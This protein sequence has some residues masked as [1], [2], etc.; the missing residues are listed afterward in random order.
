MTVGSGLLHA[1]ILCWSM[2]VVVGFA[3]SHPTLRAA[4]LAS[5]QSMWR[6]HSKPRIRSYPVR[7]Q[8]PAIPSSPDP[9]VMRAIRKFRQYV[10]QTLGHEI[11]LYLFGSRARGDFQPMSDVDVA[12]VFP[13]GTHVGL[14]AHWQVMKAAFRVML[15]DNLYIQARVLTAESCKNSYVPS[16]I[17]REG[18]LV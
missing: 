10:I 3:L 6:I 13:N 14:T 5:Y 7:R 12:I 4:L 18:I 11:T 16:T 1:L 17:G 15:Q 2:G 9:E 8:T